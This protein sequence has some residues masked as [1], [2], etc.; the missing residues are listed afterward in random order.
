MAFEISPEPTDDE[1]KAILEALALED[2]ASSGGR[3]AAPQTWGHP[4]IVEPR[5]PRQHEGY[6]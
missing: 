5:D 3:A 6:E 1:R 4:G 2:A